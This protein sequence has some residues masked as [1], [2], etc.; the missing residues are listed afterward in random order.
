MLKKQL[1][2][3]EKCDNC[4]SLNFKV[5]LNS[6]IY[7]IERGEWPYGYF[8]RDC[9]A[10]VGCHPNNY[11]PMGRMATASTRRKRSTLHELFDVIWREGWIR[12]DDAYRWLAQQL[13]LDNVNNCHIGE[14]SKEQLDWAIAIMRAHKAKEYAQF[15]R[16]KEK[17][18]AKKYEQRSRESTRIGLRKSRRA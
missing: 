15:R 1:P 12:R 8:C 18:T 9:R 2:P 13:E 11:N 6:V 7:G 17:E 5:V 3:P 10:Y 4:S 16:R 14:L